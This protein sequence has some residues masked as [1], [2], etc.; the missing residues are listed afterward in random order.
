MRGARNRFVR[1]IASYFTGNNAK[2]SG[3]P[4]YVTQHEILIADAVAKF[5]IKKGTVLI[6]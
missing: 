3:I 1:K 5:V 6:F 2:A 4:L